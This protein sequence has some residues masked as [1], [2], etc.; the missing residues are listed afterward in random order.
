MKE[1]ELIT[2]LTQV[3][4]E[5]DKG[6]KLEVASRVIN[7]DNPHYDNVNPKLVTLHDLQRYIADK[8]LRVKYEP[9]ISTRV[10]GVRFTGSI[11][12]F[13]YSDKVT[14]ARSIERFKA[15][16]TL[17]NCEW[18]HLFNAHTGE[19]LSSDTLGKSSLDEK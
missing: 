8:R 19:L 16:V 3:V 17:F 5:L 7:S 13:E 1:H 9:T 4:V 2:S 18:C 11:E 15:E 10:L 6:N 12:S 14:I